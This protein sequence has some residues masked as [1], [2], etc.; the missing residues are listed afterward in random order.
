MTSFPFIL[1]C[2]S[3]FAPADCV[4]VCISCLEKMNLCNQ[5]LDNR[6]SLPSK[7]VYLVFQS[8][9]SYLA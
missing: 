8:H 4:Y 1:R 3:A 7:H 2:R 5:D 6:L 9:V